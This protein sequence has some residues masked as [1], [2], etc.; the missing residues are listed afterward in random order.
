MLS[1]HTTIWIIPNTSAIG[2][3]SSFRTNSLIVL[4]PNPRGP[5][6]AAIQNSP[7]RV[8]ESQ[9]LGGRGEER[10]KPL[11]LLFEIGLDN[12]HGEA[13]IVQYFEELEGTSIYC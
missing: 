10:V 6:S 8:S 3:Y 1:W 9:K 5:N 13:R 11:G 12:Y 7:E 4:I 2:V